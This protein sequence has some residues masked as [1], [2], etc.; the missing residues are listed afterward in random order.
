[1]RIAVTAET[2]QGLQAPVAQ[3]FGHAPYFVLVETDA[4]E[5][6]EVEVLANPFAE[7]HQ[8]GQIPQF[9]SDQRADVMLSGGMGG[10]AIQFFTQLGIQPATG[11]AGTVAE[12]IGAFLDGRVRDAAPCD[13]SVEHGHG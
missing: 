13:N 3:H 10:R 4:A 2:D 6:T 9:I 11:A 7:A 8:P 1:M 12:S 5:V